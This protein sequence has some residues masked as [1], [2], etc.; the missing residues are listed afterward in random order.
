MRR[1][2]RRVMVSHAR[3]PTARRHDESEGLSWISKPR[4]DH[5]ER[6]ESRTH[7]CGNGKKPWHDATLPLRGVA[8][9]DRNVATYR[10]AACGTQ[11]TPSGIVAPSL[12]DVVGR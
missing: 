4:A 8:I 1:A 3:S 2:R 5:D 6:N 10:Q 7:K 11:E 12:A 9:V